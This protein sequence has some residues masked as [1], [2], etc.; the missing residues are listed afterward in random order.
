MNFT[1]QY[2][3]GSVKVYE[4]TQEAKTREEVRDYAKKR[5]LE[6]DSIEI[7]EKKNDVTVIFTNK[8]THVKVSNK[9]KAGVSNR[10]AW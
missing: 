7:S 3:V 2:Y 4:E 8:I 1:I 5:V 9:T 10:N 6:E